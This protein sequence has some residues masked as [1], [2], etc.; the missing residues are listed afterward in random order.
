M[1]SYQDAYEAQTGRVAPAQA[2][3][4]D[5]LFDKM[6]RH[7]LL[8]P[9]GQQAVDAGLTA[10]ALNDAQENPAL[11]Q[12]YRWMVTTY[13]GNQPINELPAQLI[14]RSLT[15][16]NIFQT[17]LPQPL[18]LNVWQMAAMQDFPLMT[19]RAVIVENN[20]ILIW[21]LHRHPNWPLINQEG[22][23]F[24]QPSVKMMQTLERR[25]MAYTYLGD[26]DTDG[27]E[28]ADRLYGK[29]Q[30][31][32]IEAFTALQSP[33]TV[34]KWVTLYGKTPV[35][36]HRTRAGQVQQPIFQQELNTIHLLGKFVEQEQ[37]IQQYEALISQ[38]L[39]KKTPSSFDLK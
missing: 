36:V 8:P 35:S 11:Y 17:T 19:D 13:F 25:G 28:I 16:A 26:L 34:A 32:T 39:A 12:Y 5:V 9:R 14:G 4:L 27:I 15:C 22:N 24:N 23:N 1:S 38:W 20:G 31:T 37:L 3:Q 7:E 30:R 18:T 21:L 10:H 29:L 2:A 33:L 6:A